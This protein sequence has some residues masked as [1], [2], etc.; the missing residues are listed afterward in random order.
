MVNL[1][2]FFIANEAGPVSSTVGG[3]LKTCYIVALGWIMSGRSVKDS[4]MSGILLALGGI[5]WYVL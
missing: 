2:Q 4:S 3:H 1:S 5:I